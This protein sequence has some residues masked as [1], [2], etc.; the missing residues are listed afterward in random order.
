MSKQAIGNSPHQ[1]ITLG[2]DVPRNIRR[3]ERTPYQI[4]IS[5]GKSRRLK[6]TCNTT[7][8]QV[9]IQRS[10]PK[11]YHSKLF[12]DSKYG[13]AAQSLQAAKRHLKCVQPQ[14]APRL[15]LLHYHVKVSRTNHTTGI[16]GIALH[17]ARTP[18]RPTTDQLFCIAYWRDHIRHHQQRIYVGVPQSATPARVVERVNQARRLRIQKLTEAG[19]TLSELEK[20]HRL[21]TLR[22]ARVFLRH[23]MV[24]RNGKRLAL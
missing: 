3:I 18:T 23:H 6:R 12:S 10:H 5:R 20:I 7:G 15:D 1:K 19:G 22:D 2:F 14:M 24:M 16:Q 13:G 8:W 4:K 17:W 21:F 11:Q 9:V